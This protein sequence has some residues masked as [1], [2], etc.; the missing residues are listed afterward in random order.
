MKKISYISSDAESEVTLPRP[1]G[2]GQTEMGN[3]GF[4]LQEMGAET[5]GKQLPPNDPKADSEEQTQDVINEGDLFKILINLGDAS[6]NHGNEV[7]ADFTDFLIKKFADARADSLKKYYGPTDLFNHIIIKVQKS[8][9]PNTNEVIKK[10]TK[11]Y[12]RTILL[13]YME[14]KD[15]DKSKESAYKKV[16]HRADQYLSEG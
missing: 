12:S 16:L 11:I 15:L 14:N 5:M 10:L 3:R 7:F 1:D 4:S 8:D 6:D 13:E 2:G 9:I